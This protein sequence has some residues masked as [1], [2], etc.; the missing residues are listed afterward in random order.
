M[1]ELLESYVE[2]LGPV[3]VAVIAAL[4]TIVGVLVIRHPPLL[5]WF[6][7]I[8][9]ILAGVAAFAFAATSTLSRR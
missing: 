9:L 6:A 7:G 8:A 5:A 1:Q 2:R 3:A 4:L